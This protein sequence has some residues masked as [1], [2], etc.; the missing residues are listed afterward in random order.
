MTTPYN[1]GKVR[2]GS[3]YTPR[4]KPLA[5]QGVSGPHRRRLFDSPDRVVMA[6]CALAVTALAVILLAGA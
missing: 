2:I 4:I 6:T 5:S 3:A 1:T